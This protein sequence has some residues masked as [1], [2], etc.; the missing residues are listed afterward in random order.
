MATLTIKTTN[1]E[2]EYEVLIAELSAAKALGAKQYV[3]IVQ[4]IRADNAVVDKL[5]RAT[6][7]KDDTEFTWEVMRKLMEVPTVGIPVAHVGP[8]TS[9]WANEI[10]NYLE[11]WKLP[12]GGSKE[13]QVEIDLGSQ[14]YNL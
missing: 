14:H 5:A 8:K 11:T 10:E 3:S 13:E 12:K 9:E 1:N 4:I 6:S 2:A 7:A